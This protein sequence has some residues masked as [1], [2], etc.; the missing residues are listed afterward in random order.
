MRLFYDTVVLNGGYFY[1]FPP[2][3]L[4]LGLYS[5]KHT[6]ELV[7]SLCAWISLLSL[8]SRH[9]FILFYGTIPPLDIFLGW[10][11]IIIFFMV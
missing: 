10:L 8:G 6:K 3:F 2:C 7:S 1:L 9:K 11:L 5:L 4:A